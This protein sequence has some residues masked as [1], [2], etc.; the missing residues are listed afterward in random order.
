MSEKI[1]VIAAHPDDEVLGCGGTIAKH[2]KNGGTV[3]V[4]ILAEGIT[5]R[6]CKNSKSYKKN[7]ELSKLSNSIKNA[8]N[9]LGV[10]SIITNNFPDNRMDSLNRLEIIKFIEKLIS[11]F[12]PN[13]IYT[14]FFNDLNIDHQITSECVITACRPTSN[15]SVK[16]ILFFEI[17][18]STEWQFTKSKEN[19]SPNWFID[20]SKTLDI[21]LKAIK[22]YQSE[23]RKFPHP[24]SIKSIEH[25]SHW[26]G[27]SI[28][29]ESAEAFVLSRNLE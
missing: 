19:F 25:L 18:S 6:Y 12:K 29:V 8:N 13:I 3:Y 7:K 1:L 26:R 17:P 9:I 4:A 14:H 21:K 24:R 16:R 20:I 5:S 23:L 28:G 2:I 27:S 15:Q 10:K 22:E 11:N